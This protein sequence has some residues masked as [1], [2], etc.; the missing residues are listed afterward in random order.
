MM[1][2][3]NYVFALLSTEIPELLKIGS[4]EWKKGVLDSLEIMW[5]GVLA[6]FIVITVV[7]I[8]VVLLNKITAPKKKSSDEEKA[9]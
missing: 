2:L 1:N 8:A 9:E 5:K 4:E 7:I 3:L 6:I